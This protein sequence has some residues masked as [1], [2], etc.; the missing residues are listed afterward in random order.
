MWIGELQLLAALGERGQ[1]LDIA[2]AEGAAERR[3]RAFA[4]FMRAYDACRRAIAYLR[5]DEDDADT[6][7][8]SLFKGRG[9]RRPSEPGA[10][11]APEPARAPVRAEDEGAPAQ[12]A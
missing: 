11:G 2:Q 10:D 9:G 12:P 7:A 3:L 6:I 8:P 4:L 5:W 1:P